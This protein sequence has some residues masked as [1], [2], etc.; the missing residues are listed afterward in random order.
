MTAEEVARW[1]ANKSLD[2]SACTDEE[3]VEAAV[4]F[5]R[6][7]NDSTG[8]ADTELKACDIKNFDIAAF[9]GQIGDILKEIIHSKDVDPDAWWKKGTPFNN[10]PEKMR[11]FTELSKAQ[12]LK[13]YSYLTEEDYDATY[14]VAETLMCEVEEVC[15]TFNTRY[16]DHV[17]RK[18]T[19]KGKTLP[20][21]FAAAYPSERSLRYCSGYFIRFRDTD[22][23]EQYHKWKKTGLTIE[24]YY[25]SG[26][27]D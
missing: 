14:K 9:T 2:G 27:V 11:D 7:I 3:F 8:E 1:L 12:F 26:V 19:V 22:L 18:F 20:E 6:L 5:G 23:N 17:V 24:M 10:D 13:L 16:K 25:G 15:N 21:V 4:L